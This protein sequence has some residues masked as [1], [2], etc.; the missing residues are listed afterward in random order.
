L[1]PAIE[2]QAAL[3]SGLDIPCIN[4]RTKF[5]RIVLPIVGQVAPFDVVH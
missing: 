2:E 5:K 3:F 1:L 4:K